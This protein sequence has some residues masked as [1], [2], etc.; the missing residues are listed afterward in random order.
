MLSGYLAEVCHAP[1]TVVEHGDDEPPWA[2]RLLTEVMSTPLEERGWWP[3]SA[4]ETNQACP[5]C[6]AFCVDFTTHGCLDPAC[7]EFL[8][9][10]VEQ[11]NDLIL[12]EDNNALAWL[13]EPPDEWVGFA[14]LSHTELNEFAQAA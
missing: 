11:V 5:V 14:G 8:G 4:V 7:S 13:F 6:H 9:D 12:P 2:G 1:L 3:E 10:F